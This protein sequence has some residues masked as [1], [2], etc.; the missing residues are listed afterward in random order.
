MFLFPLNCTGVVTDVGR[1]LKKKYKNK[2]DIRMVVR[3][4]IH[5][6]QKVKKKK[7]IF[8]MWLPNMV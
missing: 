3:Y 7:T 6:D 2:Y 8:L 4:I 5:M 1:K